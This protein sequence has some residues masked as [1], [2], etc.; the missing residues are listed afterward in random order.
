MNDESFSERYM[1]GTREMYGYACPQCDRPEH[2]D[3]VICG[4]CGHA[5]I[6]GA[7]MPPRGCTCGAAHLNLG[8]HPIEC[9]YFKEKTAVPELSSKPQAVASIEDFRDFVIQ[10]AVFVADV[11]D[12]VPL[13]DLINFY[14]TASGRPFYRPEPE[15]WPCPNCST[16]EG[17]ATDH[18]SANCPKAHGA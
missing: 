5:H 4:P 12:F 8:W 3:G 15:E 18:T 10:S 9:A 6:D 2:C 11:G 7:C 1:G 13:S 16:L 14:E 17:P